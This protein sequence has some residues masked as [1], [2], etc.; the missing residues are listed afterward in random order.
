MSRIATIAVAEAVAARPP[1]RAWRRFRQNRP[2]VFG[3]AAVVL[4]AVACL[5][6]IPWSIGE[7]AGQPRYN[8]Q[9]AG[10][11]LDA[12]SPAYPLGTDDLGRPVGVR[13][14]YGGA[15]SL[16]IGLAAAAISVLIGVTWGSVAGY[17][18]GRV[19]TTMMRIVD[20]LYGLP[21]ILLVILLKVA[22]EEPL[23]AWIGSPAVA[24]GVVLFVAI[25]SVSW[26][27]MA[28]V[29]RGQVLSIKAR[30]FVEAA[31]A[32]GARGGRI[33][34]RHIL[35]NLVGPVLVY[36]TLIVPQAIL[37]ESFLSFLGIGVAP[38][39]PTWGSL[40]ADGVARLNTIRVY[41]WLVLWPC[42]ALGF[43][44]LCL[45]FLGDGLRDAVDPTG[46]RRE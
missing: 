13:L 16:G 6:S 41:W 7:V 39:T 15:I 26:L 14:L 23:A 2:A 44:L 35:P 33:L 4:M 32:G 45:N 42:A 11:M 28:R 24:N 31:R 43:T 20:V 17:C 34:R 40:A 36:A 37:Q 19:D 27:T 9:K 18:G 3:L 21:Y 5:G 10:P 8:Q 38:P 30:P 1:S 25:G 29:V 46:S 22:F 12:P